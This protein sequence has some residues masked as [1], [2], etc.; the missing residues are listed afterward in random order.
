M[1]R[2]CIISKLPVELRALSSKDFASDMTLIVSGAALNS[3]T[4]TTAV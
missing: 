2:L 1:T 3:V 4:A